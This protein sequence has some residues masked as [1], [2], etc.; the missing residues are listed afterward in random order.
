MATSQHVRTFVTWSYWLAGDGDS[1][2]VDDCLD[3]VH[4]LFSLVD[5]SAS[6]SGV[7]PAVRRQAVSC[8]G[9]RGDG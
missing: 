2:S 5:T 3:K 8:R 9:V 4:R 6:K 1:N 7:T